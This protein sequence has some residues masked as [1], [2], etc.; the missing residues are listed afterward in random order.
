[1]NNDEILEEQMGIL[2]EL[3]IE[4]MSPSQLKAFATDWLVD[5]YKRKPLIFERDWQQYQEEVQKYFVEPTDKDNKNKIIKFPD[6]GVANDNNKR[7]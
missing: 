5:A 7:N 1:M 3:T 4:D 6:K 2:A